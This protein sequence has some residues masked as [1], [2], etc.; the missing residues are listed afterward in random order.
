[1]ATSEIYLQFN[2]AHTRIKDFERQYD[3]SIEFKDKQI[4]GLN[5]TGIFN[6]EI[7]VEDALALICISFDLE[8]EKKGPKNYKIK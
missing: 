1:M 2:F 5:Y 3:V 7:P 4:E 8:F 6:R